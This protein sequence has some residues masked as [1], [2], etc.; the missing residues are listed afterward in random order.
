MRS[1]VGSQGRSGGGVADDRTTRARIRDAAVRRFASVG[2]GASVRTI[3]ADAG[4]SPALVIHHFGSKEKL[5]VACDEH[6]LAWIAEAKRANM[7]KAAGGQLLEVLAQADEM[8]PLVGYVLRS[9]QAGGAVGRSFVE[10][11]VE[12]AVKYTSEA[13]EQGLARPSL[14]EE[15]RVR[16]LVYSSLG[17]LLMAMTFDPPDD[18]QDT[19]AVMRRFMGDMYLPMLELFTQGFLTTRRMLDDYLLYVG[20]PPTGGARADADGATPTEGDP[21]A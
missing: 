4:V 1:E 3:A 15:A 13:V 8:A 2:F 12:D 6:V 16:Y 10:H 11:M 9:V 5:H 7:G 19:T 17:S 20:D 18:P 14:D 21:A